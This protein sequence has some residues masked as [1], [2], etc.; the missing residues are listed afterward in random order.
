MKHIVVFPLSSLALMLVSCDFNQPLPNHGAYDSLNSP[1]AGDQYGS[2]RSYGSLFTPGAFLQTTSSV[3]AFYS[4]FPQDL[5][6][7]NKTLPNNTEVK[8]IS[9][10]GNY[11]KVEVMI[12]GDVGYIPAVMLGQKRST[13]QVLGTGGIGQGGSRGVSSGGGGQPEVPDIAPPELGDPSRPSE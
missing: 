12:T 13:N 9:S 10:K 7:P 11:V 3:T 1:G 6:Q 8:V 5:E 2:A 4:R